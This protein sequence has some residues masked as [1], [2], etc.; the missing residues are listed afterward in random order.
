MQSIEID[1]LTAFITDVLA[2]GYSISVDD[3]KGMILNRSRDR[4]DIAV[5][6]WRKSGE[7]RIFVMNGGEN[8]GWVWA[9]WGAGENFIGKVGANEPDHGERHA[10][11]IDLLENADNVQHQAF[12]DSLS[13]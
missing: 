11:M 1:I 8:I 5:A 12:L 4:R 10:I 9:N 6:T 2:A 3:G 13:D 7:V